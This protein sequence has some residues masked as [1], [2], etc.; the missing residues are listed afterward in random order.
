MLV[1]LPVV[2]DMT[3]VASVMHPDTTAREEARTVMGE[4]LKLLEGE[5]DDGV[6]EKLFHYGERISKMLLSVSI[7]L[8][9]GYEAVFPWR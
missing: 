6:S 8:I 5:S 4:P 9:L 3:I 7:V 1:I 2:V